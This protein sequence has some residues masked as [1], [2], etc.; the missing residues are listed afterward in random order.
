[1]EKQLSVSLEDVKNY[2]NNRPCNIRHSLEPVGSKEYFNDVEKR[3]YM[4]EPHILGF[5]E[6]DR[7]KGK[8]VLEIGCGIGTAAAS[9]AKAGAIY[10][11]IELSDESLKLAKQRFEVF[12]LS[13][14]FYS[15]NAEELSNIVPVEQYDLIYSFGVI[16]HSPNPQK[17]IKEIKKFMGSNSEFRMMLYAKNS[18]KNI[19][20]DAGLDQPEAQSGCPIAFTY[21]HQEIREMLS[22]FK[23]VKI[24]QDHIFPYVVEKYV[25]YEYE[26]QPWFKAMPESMFK[27]LEQKLGWHT[28]IAA[29]L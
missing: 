25:K 12:N 11:S 7:W 9:F 14:T 5:T 21:T 27:A 15:G 20:I 16:H 26:I 13:G 29:K 1:M 28:M 22:D 10:S 23:E 8:K 17:I 3:K 6:F 24:W 18:W 2:W 4:V 19:M